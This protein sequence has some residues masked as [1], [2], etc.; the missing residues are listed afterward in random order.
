MMATSS[1]EKQN[2]Y[3]KGTAGMHTLSTLVTS[4]SLV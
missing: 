2:D 3:N 1:A 4:L